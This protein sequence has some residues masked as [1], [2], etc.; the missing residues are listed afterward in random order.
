MAPRHALAGPL[1]LLCLWLA[2]FL[3][4][5]PGSVPEVHA[6]SIQDEVELGEKFHIMIH[7]RLPLVQVEGAPIVRRRDRLRERMAI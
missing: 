4:A 7:S 1:V 6:F 3:I 5:G 2:A